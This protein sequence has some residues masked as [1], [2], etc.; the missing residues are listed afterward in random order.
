MASRLTIQR[1]LLSGVSSSSAF[2]AR[3]S[4]PLILRT[5]ATEAGSGFISRT[6]KDQKDLVHNEPSGPKIVTSTIPG[7]KTKAG[8]A[9][10]DNLQDTRAAT[11]MTGKASFL[12]I[13]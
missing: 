11:M 5:F 13:Y 7:P 9:H 4:H 2:T 12:F 1:T 3:A 8:L 6:H 10:L